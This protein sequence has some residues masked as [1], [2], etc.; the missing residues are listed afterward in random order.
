MPTPQMRKLR[1]GKDRGAAL[2]EV[3][4]PSS[5]GSLAS[6]SA[7]LLPSCVHLPLAVALTSRT[8]SS[9]VSRPSVLLCAGCFP[10]T[11]PLLADHGSPS[12]LWVQVPP[13]VFSLPGPLSPSAWLTLA[14]C[15]CCALPS[16]PAVAPGA[17]PSLPAHLPACRPSPSQTPQP[18]TTR[19]P[20][21]AAV[22]VRVSVCMCVCPDRPW[23]WREGTPM[24]SPASLSDHPP[25]PFSTFPTFRRSGGGLSPTRAGSV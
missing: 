3:S 11:C 4:R 16:V 7:P 20:T 21:P 6:E 1:H 23:R 10:V 12:S 18:P 2:L 24:T 5:S 8:P 9:L 14:P 13:A 15:P 25:F 17:S 22:C 19:P